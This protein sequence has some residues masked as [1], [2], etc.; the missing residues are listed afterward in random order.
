MSFEE[1]DEFPL[2][3]FLYICFMSVLFI[4]YIHYSSVVL[5]YVIAAVLNTYTGKDSRV[6]IGA[7]SA[8]HAHR[9]QGTFK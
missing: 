1:S 6:S 7:S 5:A 3:F 8:Q 4:F 2:S 9:I